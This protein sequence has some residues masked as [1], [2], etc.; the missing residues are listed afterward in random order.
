MKLPKTFIP[1][2]NLENNINRLMFEKIMVYEKHDIY[3]NRLKI[4]EGIRIGHSNKKLYTTFD[5][6]LSILKKAGY[7]RH[8]YP[9]EH[10]EIVIQHLEGKLD[11]QL[12]NLARDLRSSN[13]CWLNMAIK[14]SG[15]ML[16]C[17]DNPKNMEWRKY[18]K[19]YVNCS[20]Q[21]NTNVLSLNG[22]SSQEWVKLKSFDNEFV[23][24]FCNRN[25]EELPQKMQEESAIYLP[26]EGVLWPISM[27]DGGL[28]ICGYV[29]YRMC[30]GVKE[31]K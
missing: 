10:F 2:N 17:Y 30:R 16:L 25:F 3:L 12:Y 7:E 28:S 24:F 19:K 18:K 11:G 29:T 13:G 15:D 6:S 5:Q 23:S 26:P 9:W 21:K 1:E 4:E 8:L 14:R 20:T 22:V 27:S 31:R